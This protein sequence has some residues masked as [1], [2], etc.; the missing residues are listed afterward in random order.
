MSIS[1]EAL[2]SYKTL[3]ANDGLKYAIL[4]IDDA[5]NE[6]VLDDFS[7]D[8]RDSDMIKTAGTTEEVRAAFDQLADIIKEHRTRSP[9]FCLFNFSLNEKSKT[10][11]IYW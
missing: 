9:R 1:D 7:D 3:L 5:A 11:L 8:M 10:A 6:L 4:K 2:E